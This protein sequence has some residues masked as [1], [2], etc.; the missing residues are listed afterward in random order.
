[1]V[2]PSASPVSQG[3]IA[4]SEELRGT[5]DVWVHCL[6]GHPKMGHTGGEVELLEWMKCFLYHTKSTLVTPGGFSR[7]MS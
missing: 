1:M 5:A 2:G 3:S 7:I 6:S 4:G